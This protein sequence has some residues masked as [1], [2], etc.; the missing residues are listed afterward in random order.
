MYHVPL[1]LQ[2][3]IDAMMKE[4]K[5]GEDGI[6][7]SGRGKRVGNFVEVCRKRGLKVNAGKGILM[8]L[9]GGIEV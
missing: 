8:V 9:N 5:D 2:Y 4:V 6:E 7:I 1:D 3:I